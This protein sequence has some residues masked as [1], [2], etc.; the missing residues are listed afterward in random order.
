MGNSATERRWGL[1]QDADVAGDLDSKINVGWHVVYFRKPHVFSNKLNLQEANSFV[2]SSIEAEIIASDAGLKLGGTPSLNVWDLVVDVLEP[3]AR[4]NPLHN[5]KLP[6]TKSL[7]ADKRL[8]DS[9][10]CDLPKRAQHQPTGI[11]FRF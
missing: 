1:F 7:M 11:S 4:R 3:L 10:D 2:H 8:T 9:I 6:K 5:T